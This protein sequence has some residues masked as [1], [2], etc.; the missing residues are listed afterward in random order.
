MSTKKID[1]QRYFAAV[2]ICLRLRTPH[3][4][5]P[6]HTVYVYTVYRE[7]GTRESLTREKVRGIENTNINSNKHLPQSPFTGQLF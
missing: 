7:G 5:L 6:L 1:L 4:A 2:V 3:T